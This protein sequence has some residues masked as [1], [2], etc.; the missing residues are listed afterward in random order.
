MLKEFQIAGYISFSG[1][2][3]EAINTMNTKLQSE[4]IGEY[5]SILENLDIAWQNNYL[6]K[7]NSFKQRLLRLKRDGFMLKEI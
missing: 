4:I 2:Y 5:F 7:P 3:E 6:T 1:K